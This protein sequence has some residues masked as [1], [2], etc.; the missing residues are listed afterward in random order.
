[1]S[2]LTDTVKEMEE[3]RRQRAAMEEW[4]LLQSGVVNDWKCNPSKLRPEA[5]KQEMAAM[6]DL[7]TIIGEKKLK[8]KADM[9]NSG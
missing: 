8:I 3:A 6:T 4:I 5:A 9:A 1:M 7:M 2:N